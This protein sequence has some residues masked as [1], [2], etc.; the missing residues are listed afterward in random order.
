MSWTWDG[1]V[2]PVIDE[3]DADSI[4]PERQP[5]NVVKH[6][7]IGLGTVDSTIITDM[8]AP[9]VE[10]TMRFRC[11]AAMEAILVALERTTFTVIDPW[12]ASRDWYLER[13]EISHMPQSSAAA[14]FYDI[15]AFM[16]ER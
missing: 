4:Y 15:T 14:P 10:A 13:L 1:T 9:S 3:P 12:A 16:V 8:G 5:R 2:L 7:P 6:H 11:T